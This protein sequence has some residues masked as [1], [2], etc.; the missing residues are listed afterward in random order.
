MVSCNIWKVQLN[1]AEPFNLYNHLY[2]VHHNCLALFLQSV[3]AFPSKCVQSRLETSCYLFAT[4]RLDSRPHNSCPLFHSL[5]TSVS[6][7]SWTE[8]HFT[9]SSSSSEMVWTR[10]VSLGWVQ[11]VRFA[12]EPSRSNCVC[13]CTPTQQTHHIFLFCRRKHNPQGISLLPVW[14]LLAIYM[15]AGKTLPLSL[16]L[17]NPRGSDCT[18]VRQI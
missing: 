10:V 11:V 1:R 2:N 17:H 16:T 6:I 3:F 12:Q 4:C 5:S 7:P 8:R 14:K 9:C 13:S 15:L 18:A